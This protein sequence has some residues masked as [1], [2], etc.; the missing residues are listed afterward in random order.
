V[1]KQWRKMDEDIENYQCMMDHNVSN[2][3]EQKLDEKL[4]EYSNVA[5]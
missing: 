1:N 3:I 2:N 4:T 5:R